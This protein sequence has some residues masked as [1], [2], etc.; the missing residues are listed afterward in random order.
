M[1]K[2]TD[3]IKVNKPEETKVKFNMNAGDKNK[4]A[5]DLLMSDSPE[6]LN[7]NQWKTK[8][9]NNNLNHARYLIALAQYYP[10]GPN[11]FMFGG[12]YK[13]EII[14]PK[15][16]DGP[17]YKLT[18][19]DDYKEYIKRLII[20]VEKPIGRNS[21]NRKY[22]SIQKN[23]NPEIYELAPNNKLGTFPG[24]Q[25]VSLSHIQLQQIFNQE[26]PSWKQALSNV[27]GVYVITD[28]SNGELYIGSASGNTEGIWQRWINYANLTNLTGGNKAFI[29]KM[30]QDKAYV[31]KNFQ[32][33]IIEIFDTKTKKDTILERENY[34]K[35][36]FDTKNHGMNYN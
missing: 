9:S 10:Y 22:E 26:E 30:K 28:L 12:I 2:F 14:D 1:I 6:W 29:E 19:M 23:L 34:W 31:V 20:K 25:S 16:F 13:V 4:L 8:Q 5:L 24:Y 35:R 17:G 11:Y 33:S 7:M 3:F 15:I 36:V 18:L 27:K 32:Y 21:Y